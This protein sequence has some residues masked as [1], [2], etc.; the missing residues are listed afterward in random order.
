[1]RADARFASTKACHL[2]DF[3]LP[4]PLHVSIKYWECPQCGALH[5]RDVNAWKRLGLCRVS[6][7]SDAQAPV[8]GAATVNDDL[9]GRQLKPVST[10]AITPVRET[11]QIRPCRLSVLKRPS[12]MGL[13]LG[14]VVEPSDLKALG[15]GVR[16]GEL[17]A[18]TKV[19]LS[20]GGVVRASELAASDRI[21]VQ[22]TEM[23]SL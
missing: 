9:V 4:E 13:K 23:S 18:A 20:N 17:L 15:A 2:C 6:L 3:N 7:E 19:R 1:M 22:D 14:R 16:S 5:H 21:G 11:P 8:A 12:Y 10:E